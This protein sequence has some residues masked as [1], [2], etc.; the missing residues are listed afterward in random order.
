MDISEY[1][2]V[3]RK[4]FEDNIKIRDL[5][6]KMLSERKTIM[7]KFFVDYYYSIYGISPSVKAKTI[8]TYMHDE[9]LVI[10]FSIYYPN[11]T[12]S[13]ILE[14]YD[15]TIV[16]S[17]KNKFIVKITSD[18]GILWFFIEI[19][20]TL[21]ECKIGVIQFNSHVS[22]V[23]DVPV[24]QKRRIVSVSHID[25]YICS[26][27]NRHIPDM[28]MC[29]GCHDVLKMSVRY[30]SKKCQSKDYNEKHKFVCGANCRIFQPASNALAARQREWDIVKSV[31]P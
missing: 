1:R 23:F 24:P 12:V 19:H 25:P 3:V 6:P 2:S 7:K 14:N 29:K 21:N 13:T 15:A 5:N 10:P 18:Y 11:Y 20:T 17:E 16:N 30:C 4:V 8:Y 27:C 22:I 9:L 26:R 28:L 31:L